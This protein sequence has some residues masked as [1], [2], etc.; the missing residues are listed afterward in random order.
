MSNKKKLQT[1][2]NARSWESLPKCLNEIRKIE[3]KNKYDLRF[4]W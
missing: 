2:F 1:S 4:Y 3:L